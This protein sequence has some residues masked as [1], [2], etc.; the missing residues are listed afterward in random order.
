MA[1]KAPTYIKVN[2]RLYKKAAADPDVN[3]ALT[4]LTSAKEKFSKA[5]TPEEVE[6]AKAELKQAAQ[7]LLSSIA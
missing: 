4:L 5:H 6:Q 1:T 3:S 2:G 7:N